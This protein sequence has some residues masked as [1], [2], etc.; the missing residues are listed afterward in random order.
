MGQACPGPH[1]FMR[2][3]RG[4]GLLRHSSHKNHKTIHFRCVSQA[5]LFGR[6]LS[7]GRAL[8]PLLAP[9]GLKKSWRMAAGPQ[10]LP[11]VGSNLGAFVGSGIAGGKLHLRSRC[12]G[13]A[14]RRIFTAQT[15]T[16]YYD[17]LTN[18]LL[19]LFVI[20]TSRVFVDFD[21]FWSNLCVC[22][23]NRF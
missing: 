18:L 3:F 23:S 19:V 5:H 15:L 1:L 17:K 16:G 12:N 6:G 8:G 21:R 4:A 20:Y 13:D 14:R 9:L 7:R 11:R 10:K 22:S 2:D